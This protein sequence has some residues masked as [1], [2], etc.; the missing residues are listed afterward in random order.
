MSECSASDSDCAVS[1]SQPPNISVRPLLLA[2]ARRGA[3]RHTSASV[4]GDEEVATGDRR[5][6]VRGGNKYS[7]TASI[8]HRSID[9]TSW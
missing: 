6:S 3:A 1:I 7:L 2:R 4:K 9:R 8:S 5:E